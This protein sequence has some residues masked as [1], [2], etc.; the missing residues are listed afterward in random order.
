MTSRTCRLSRLYPGILIFLKKD[1]DIVR[2]FW[3]QTVKVG[4]AT[5]IFLESIAGRK[6]PGWN[7]RVFRALKAELRLWLCQL[8]NI[9]ADDLWSMIED[10]GPGASFFLALL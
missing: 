1:T 8:S 6:L 10:S 9:K 2:I 5:T 3:E 7:L 4:V